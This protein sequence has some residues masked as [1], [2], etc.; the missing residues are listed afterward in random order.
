[1]DSHYPGSTWASGGGDLV[2][3]GHELHPSDDCSYQTLA[4]KHT[5]RPAHFAR[6]RRP[7]MQR[8]QEAR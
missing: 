5:Q 8:H 2:F 3:Q 1:M 7:T 4:F 6:G